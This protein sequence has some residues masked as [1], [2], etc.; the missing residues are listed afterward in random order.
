MKQ[1]PNE[2]AERTAAG[3]FEFVNPWNLD[4]NGDGAAVKTAAVVRFRR[5][6]K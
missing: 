1:T 2:S 4:I 3:R 5:S 6:P